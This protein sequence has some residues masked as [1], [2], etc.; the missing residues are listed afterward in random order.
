M[1][2]AEVRAPRSLRRVLRALLVGVAF[3]ASSLTAAII[4][5]QHRPTIIERLPSNRLRHAA[6]AILGWVVPASSGLSRKLPPPAATVIGMNLPEIRYYGSSFPFANLTTGAGWLN[7]R[8]KPLSDTDQDV[9][10]DIRSLP[11]DGVALRFLWVPPTGLG[12]S[13]IRCTYRGSGT[14][15]LAGGGSVIATAPNILRFR[16]TNSRGR[17]PF[18]WLVLKDVVPQ[19]PMRD[20]DCREA[21]LARTARFRP[22]FLATLRGYRVIRFMDWQNANANEAIDWRDRHMPAGNRIDRDGVAIEDMLALV[23]ELGADPWFVMPWNAD[24]DYVNRFA[25]MTRSQLPPGR[26]VY[27]EVGNEVW[28][29][30]FPVGRQAVAEGLAR[31]L[32]ASEREAGLRR[33]AERTIEVMRPWEAAFAGRRGLIRVLST[34]HVLPETAEIALSYGDTAA[35]VDAL[36]TAPYFGTILGGTKNTRDSSLRVLAAILPV[37]IQQAIDNRR[38]AVRHDKRYLAYEGGQSL[39]L[40]AQVQLLEQLQH[41]PAMYDLYRRYLSMWRH[42][43]GDVLCLLTSV[44]PPGISG[45]WGL[46]EREDETPALAPKLRAVREAQY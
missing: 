30:G 5:V 4:A 12:G 16:L 21:G 39:V 18:P 9:N 46:A 14:L 36:A 17:P 24:Q 8:W 34:Q 13:E 43:V 6:F 29:I 32:G 42:Q 27:V 25:L 23:R 19:R 1:I 33:Y 15:S 45:A 38:I 31:Q 11:V 35:H 40:P 2:V 26:N 3:I 37:S 20:L 41:D 22:A 10:G 7:S 28:N 44:A